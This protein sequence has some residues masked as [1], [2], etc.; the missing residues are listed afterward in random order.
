[1]II[2]NKYE[3][4]EKISEGTFGT[5]Y[6]GKKLKN[7]TDVAV[8]LNKSD[9]NFLKQECTIMHYLISKKC[10]AVPDIY[11]YGL[12]D[13]YYIVVMKYC[14]LTLSEFVVN[15]DN[16]VNIMEN[17]FIQCIELLHEFHENMVIHCDIKPDNIMVS[18]NRLYIIDFGLSQFYIEDDD[19]ATDRKTQINGTPRYVS[20]F[21][22]QGFDY[23]PKDDIISLC[24]VFY[25]LYTPLP[26]DSRG[27][28]N[29]IQH[30]KNK[31]LCLSKIRC[32]QTKTD[33]PFLIRIINI[34][35]YCYTLDD[36]KQIDYDLLI[37]R[38]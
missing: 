14:E 4:T 5:V 10:V 28:V 37:Q 23:L 1:M 25:E 34:L 24:Y 16:N 15:Y 3:I 35:K 12:I 30:E 18:D 19:K 29:D 9:I 22:H 26:W 8:K 21:I 2:K 17:M 27:F 11:Y 32:I 31:E 20:P 38:V 33:V 7:N 13:K 6:K 36:D